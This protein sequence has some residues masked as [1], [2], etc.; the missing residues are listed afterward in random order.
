[1]KAEG[2]G[3]PAGPLVESVPH[4]AA[5]GPEDLDRADDSGAGEAPDYSD[6]AFDAFGAIIQPPR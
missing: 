2:W 6:A 3:L 5:P 1:M 4:H